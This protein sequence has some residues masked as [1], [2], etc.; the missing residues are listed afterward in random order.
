MVYTLVLHRSNGGGA[1][2]DGIGGGVSVSLE[3]DGS[4]MVESVRVQW[5][6]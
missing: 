4:E 6:S 3:N 2:S 5:R 1:G